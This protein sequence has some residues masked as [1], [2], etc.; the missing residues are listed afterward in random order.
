MDSHSVINSILDYA[1]S[2]EIDLIVIGTKGR[3]GLKR[4]LMGSV[5]NGVVQHAHCPV[6]LVR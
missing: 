3:T 2:R 5:A 4:F 1:V 6:L